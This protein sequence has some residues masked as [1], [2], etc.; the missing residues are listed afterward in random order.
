M[1][2]RV[3]CFGNA[4][5]RDDGAAIHVARELRAA[6]EKAGA[7]VDVV[8]S[9][10]AGYDLLELMQ[11]W[12][13]VILV[14]AVQLADREAGALLELNP[15]DDET[16]LR[17]CSSREGNIPTVMAAGEKLGYSMPREILLYGIQGE[18]LCT[19]GEGLSPLVAAA[20]PRVVSK[21]LEKVGAS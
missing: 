9:A 4:I 20:V 15:L 1:R 19:F 21:I 17:L 18:D 3:I 6:L 12:E 7:D 16:Y 14:E 8:E 13:R 11:D 5:M 10:V 2:T